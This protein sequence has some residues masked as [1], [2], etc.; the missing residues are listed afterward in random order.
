MNDEDFPRRLFGEIKDS[1]GQTIPVQADYTGINDDGLKVFL[2]HIP[3]AFWVVSMSWDQ[4][5]AQSILQMEV[6][7]R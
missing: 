7:D 6:D 3:K 1:Q 5:P 4:M 2:C